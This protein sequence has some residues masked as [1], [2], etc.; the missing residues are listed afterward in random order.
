[1]TVVPGKKQISEFLGKVPVPR[2]RGVWLTHFLMK[3]RLV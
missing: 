1:M 2:R 3:V